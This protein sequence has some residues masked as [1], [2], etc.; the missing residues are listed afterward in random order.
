MT[1]EEGSR[2]AVYREGYVPEEL[3]HPWENKRYIKK[4][5]G[6]V[7]AESTKSVLDVRSS[8]KPPKYNLLVD[9]D[10]PFH[11]PHLQNFFD[12]IRGK[13][14]LN[15]P[16][17]IGYETAVA[18]LKVNEAVEAARRLDFKPEDFLV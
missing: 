9:M 14:K 2:N 6:I 3:W 7:Q 11:Q 13:A 17:E 4:E 8:P 16:G 12:A 1:S 5:N 15:C 18:V 10:Q